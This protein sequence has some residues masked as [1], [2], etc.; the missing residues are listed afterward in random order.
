M[1]RLRL[2]FKC[3]CQLCRFDH[4]KSVL[5]LCLFPTIWRKSSQAIELNQVFIFW[6]KDKSAIFFIQEYVLLIHL[7][8]SSLALDPA[9]LFTF[10]KCGDVRLSENGHSL[11]RPENSFFQANSFYRPAPKLATVWWTL[12][13]SENSISRENLLPLCEGDTGRRRGLLSSRTWLSLQNPF[14]RCR[15]TLQIK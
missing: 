2:V 15:I 6:N 9:Q 7:S 4:S 5:C 3:C 1:K 10:C 13:N 12:D 11:D 8:T 14:Q